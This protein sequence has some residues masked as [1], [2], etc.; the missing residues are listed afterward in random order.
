MSIFSLPAHIPPPHHLL[1]PLLAFVPPIP[2]QV[3]P[4]WAC[5]ARLPSHN[6][7]CPYIIQNLIEPLPHLSR[8]DIG[9]LCGDYAVIKG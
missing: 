9:L 6:S 3:S 2:H 8:D 4:S 7:K 1:T 5:Q